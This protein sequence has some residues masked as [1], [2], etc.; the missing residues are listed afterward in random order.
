MN[1]S[2]QPAAQAA[3]SSPANTI[4][5]PSP[6]EM[7]HA[8]VHD[9][10]ELA[11]TTRKTMYELYSR[12]YDGADFARFKHDLTAKEY[13]IL[14]KDPN[15]ELRGFSTLVTFDIETDRS[16]TARAIYSGDTIVDDRCWGQQT[17]AFTWI[18]LAGRVAARAPKSALY[19]FLIVKGHRTYRYLNAFAHRYYPHW[20]EATPRGVQ[21]LI[22]Q[23]A[24]RR[25]GRY[26]EHESGIVRFPQSRDHLKPKWAG[27]DDRERRRPEVAFFLRRNPGYTRGDELVCLTEL[28]VPNLRP[29]ARRLF[30]QG[31]RA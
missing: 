2:A 19:W 24:A 10:I 18:K 25:F 8:E 27:V 17:L 14:L 30:E 21:L 13:A 6:A 23:L 12:Y 16:S 9:V 26:Y 1:A 15:S 11:P 3:K 22:D 20:R 29:L 28:A 5:S 4:L 31:L 7:L